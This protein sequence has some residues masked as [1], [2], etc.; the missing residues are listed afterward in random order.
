MS[1]MSQQ[2]K[3]SYLFGSNA[4]FIEDLYDQYLI[5]PTAVDNKW[6]Q[7]FDSIQ[8]GN[9]DVSH[10]KLKE[11]FALIL[12]HSNLLTSGIASN[13]PVNINDNQIKVWQ[14]V[15]SYRA[16]GYKYADLDPLAKYAKVKPAEFDISPYQ[17]DINNSE[18]FSLDYTS[19]TKWKIKDIIQRLK[20]IYCGSIGFDFTHIANKEQ[21]QWLI[22]Y[23]ENNYI[24]FQLSTNEKLTV[25]NKLAQ[26]DGF[27]KYLHTQFVG[28]K[29][30]SIEGA[31]SLIPL[32][33]HAVNTSVKY[34][35]KEVYLGM[36]HRGRLNTLVNLLGK[37]P[38]TI[39]EEFNGIYPAKEFLTS[40][41]VK[42][43]KGYKCNYITESGSVKLTLSYNPSHLE[44]VNP[45]INGMVR[46][47]SD[48]LNTPNSTL[49]I[50]IHGDSALIGLG[51][52]QGVLSMSQTRAYGV[53]GMLHI[54]VNNQVGF[55]NSNLV[56]NRSSLFCSDIMKMIDAPVLHVNCDDMQSVIFATTMALEYKAK[57]NK[58]IM[59]DLVCFR[60]YGHNEADD[61]TL[62]QPVMYAKVKQHPGTF[63]LYADKLIAQGVI[64]Q[65]QVTQIVQDYRAS[66]AK[67]EHP[68]ADKMQALD[69][70]ND[71][72]ITP[73]LNSSNKDR[74]DT[75]VSL[76][77][78]GMLTDKL[79]EQ[80][81]D[82]VVHPMIKKLI[83]TR[84][85]MGH[86]KQ[87]LDFGMAEML[88][89]ASLL[90]TGIN[91]RITGEDSGRGTFA[92]RHAVWHNT[93]S[94]LDD[95]SS[96]YVSLTNTLNNSK[97]SIYDSILNEECVLAFE[98]GYST[99]RLNDLVIWEAQ[100]GDF[101]N[102]A[103]VVIDQFIAT[104]EAKWG[105][106][107]N[108]VLM[109]PHGYDGQGPEHSS[110]RLERFLQ[111]C[112]EDNMQVVQLSTA[113]QMFHLLRHK[114][115]TAWKKPLV[116]ML[117]KRLL[118]Y[119]DAM[120]PISGFTNGAFMPVL[121]DNIDN[122]TSATKV[123]LCSGQIYY[124]LLNARNTN[125]QSAKVALIRL[126]QLYPFPLKDLGLELAKYVSVQ[127]FIWLQEEPYNQGAWLQIRE[128]LDSLV[129][130]KKQRFK[131]ISRMS[132][133]APATGMTDLHA[134]QLASIIEEA[135]K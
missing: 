134:S 135:F 53:G 56:D 74:I 31:D 126:E 63:K 129:M 40:G 9:K 21:R 78:L 81:N 8:V 51:T 37:K 33:T 72:D 73:V 106:L 5:N 128:A 122:Y 85:A 23:A 89:Y 100:F 87:N 76:E 41:D 102:G 114:A 79:S 82:F 77:T 75:A 119:R 131:S 54:V 103:Q 36:A 57:F 10:E 61:P 44:I 124:E 43:H 90:N 93:N 34:G 39:F 62:T 46:A 98:Y 67:G 12:Q 1:S 35:V 118:R 96:M 99:M 113:A 25:L 95:S 29:R 64:S 30:F 4:D 14:L 115:L 104:S 26:A 68:E 55:T 91:V 42:Y 32:L 84:N 109:L 3:D 108:L 65:E 19:E 133:A 49:G 125:N 111:L 11:K 22:N 130:H 27:D 7:Y 16:E 58:D 47:S 132:A 92:H 52:N 38:Q 86:G 60:R 24:D 101:A 116:I 71:F 94:E 70:Y 48:S 66:L 45:V 13:V 110:A 69:W 123:I 121:K 28:Q 15:A 97:V 117:S 50:L 20:Q 17:L 105:V 80:P 18:N 88:A 59:I 6:H 127:E 2:A 120:S 83:T 107:N 112:A